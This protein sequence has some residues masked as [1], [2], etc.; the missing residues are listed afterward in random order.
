MPRTAPY[1]SESFADGISSRRVGFRWQTELRPQHGAG[2]KGNSLLWVE[3][4]I[5]HIVVE[6]GEWRQADALYV[7][8]HAGNLGLVMLINFSSQQFEP[9]VTV[10]LTDGQS[11][12]GVN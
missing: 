6:V 8:F 5:Q 10:V 2:G 4:L 11:F 12:I 9:R 3:Q 1:Q 7:A